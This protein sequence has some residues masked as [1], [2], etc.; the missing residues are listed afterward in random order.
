MVYGFVKQSKGHITIYS[1]LEVGTT[2]KMYLPKASDEMAREAVTKTE[3]DAELGTETILL[4]EDDEFVR[5][6][7]ESQLR[8]LGYEV[9]VAANGPEA[10]AILE[11]DAHIDLLFTDVVMS[12]GMNGRQLAEQAQR[13]RPHLKVLYTS[14]YTENVIVHH[15]R[16]DEG[17]QL[18]SKPYARTDLAQKLREVLDKS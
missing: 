11:M 9:I 2:V 6:F 3:P 15:G 18:L 17:A 7:A 10:V 1:E 4:V 16:L 14:G 5:Q 12:G 8:L 13:L